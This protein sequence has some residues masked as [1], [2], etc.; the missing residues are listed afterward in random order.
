[1]KKLVIKNIAP[2]LVLLVLFPISFWAQES[3]GSNINV[4]YE[5]PSS[6]MTSY[7]INLM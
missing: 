5:Y 4:Q 6:S 3:G 1:M 2:L 7:T